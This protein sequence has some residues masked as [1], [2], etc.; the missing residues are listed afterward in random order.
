[1]RGVVSVMGSMS[2]IME[3]KMVMASMMVT[4]A[5]NGI[6]TLYDNPE[7]DVVIFP[8]EPRPFPDNLSTRH[9]HSPSDN[10][11]PESGGSV[12]PSTAMEAIRRQGTIRLVK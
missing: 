10:F 5:E 6:V 3:E 8:G 7:P 4:P 9:R 12:K 2:P 1:M 11:S